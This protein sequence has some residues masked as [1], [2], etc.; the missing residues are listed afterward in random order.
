MCVCVHSRHM[1]EIHSNLALE[2]NYAEIHIPF[3]TMKY[4][5]GILYCFGAKHIISTFIS[6]QCQRLH[7][8]NYHHITDELPLPLPLPLPMPLMTFHGISIYTQ[9]RQ[10]HMKLDSLN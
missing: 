7:S 6:S 2:I 5:L 8:S 9:Y 4:M 1:L 10:T 3:V